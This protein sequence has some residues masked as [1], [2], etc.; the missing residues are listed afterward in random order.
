MLISV[1]LPIYNGLPYLQSAIESI[2]VQDVDF[3]LIVSDDMSSDGSVA[4]V[5]SFADSRIRLLQ[6]SVNRGIFGNLNRCLEEAHSDLIQIFSQDDVMRPGYLA[7]Q[8]ACLARHPDAGFIYGTPEYIDEDGV[9]LGAFAGDTTPEW[10]EWPL[11]LWISSHYGALPASISSVMIPRR[12]FDEVGLFDQDYQVAGDLEFYNRVAER[13]AVLRNMDVLHAVRSHKQMTSA[14]S[15]SGAKYLSEEVKLDAWYRARWNA[16]DWQKVARFRT[17]T[18]GVN[19]LGW[20][21]RTARKGRVGE[22]LNAVAQLNRLYPIETIVRWQ[23]RRLVGA[24]SRPTPEIEPPAQ[25]PSA[26]G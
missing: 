24:D 7:S 6:N 4:L 8:A 25:K 19:H 23:F 9:S 10:I 1:V 5:Q 21:W 12:V 18:R 17:L 16:A 20:I 11:Y 15:T 2:L 26:A 22:V 14:L 13:R 3:E